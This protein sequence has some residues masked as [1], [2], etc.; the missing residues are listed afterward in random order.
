VFVLPAAGNTKFIDWE[1]L[2]T[3]KTWLRLVQSR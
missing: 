2:S 1:K 3:Q